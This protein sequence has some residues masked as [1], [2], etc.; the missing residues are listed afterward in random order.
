MIRI[1][2]TAGALLAL[3]AC[4]PAWA[5]ETATPDA[6]A[7]QAAID[8][9]PAPAGR[10]LP[11]NATVE[12]EITEAI[13]SKTRRRGERFGL[14]LRAPLL[15]D[16]AVALPAGTPGVGEIIH[17]DHAHGGGKPGELLLAARYLEYAGV[18]IPLR[19]FR[20]GATGKDRSDAALTAGI[21][22][23]GPFAHFIHGGEVEVPVAAAAQARLSGDVALPPEPADPAAA[24]VAPAPTAGP[25]AT[26]PPGAL[27]D[28]LPSTAT[29]TTT[30]ES[31]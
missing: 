3:A 17:A 20:I 10:V 19:G 9:T 1:A 28:P 24:P 6:G 27:P 5:Q 15:V 22:A 8:A 7:P 30:G 13:S 12:L 29:Q 26:P 14:R 31:P 25:P 11:A 16:G 23:L 18:R 4:A 21:I 2:G